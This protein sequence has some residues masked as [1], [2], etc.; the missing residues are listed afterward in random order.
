MQVLHPKNHNLQ[1]YDKVGALLIFNKNRGWWSGSIMDDIDASMI[2]NHKYGPTVL[3]VSGGVFSA[4]LWMCKNQKAGNK[5]AENLDSDFVIRAA[6]PYLGRI[7]SDFVDLSK[8]CLK[9]CYKFE[10]FITEK[11]SFHKK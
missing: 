9:D 3:Q 11:Y 1:G 7:Y 6:K 8:T 4:F 2:M 10:S 5:W